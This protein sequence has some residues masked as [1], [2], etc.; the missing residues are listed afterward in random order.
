[1]D[2]FELSIYF[3]KNIAE[4]Y[5]RLSWQ[6]FSLFQAPLLRVYFRRK[7]DEWTIRK[8]RPISLQDV[9][10]TH[11]EFLLESMEEFFGSKRSPSKKS[12]NT[13]YDV[14]LLVNP[15]EKIPPS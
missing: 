5:S 14:A 8:I 3:G 7:D 1:G 11:Q 2:D 15:D 9:P 12:R 10:G 13:K 4:K 6:I